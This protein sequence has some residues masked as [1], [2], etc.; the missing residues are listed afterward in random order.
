[1][2]DGSLEMIIWVDPL[3]RIGSWSRPNRRVSVATAGVPVLESKACYLPLNIVNHFST[4]DISSHHKIAALL[5]Y[6]CYSILLYKTRISDEFDQL[7]KCMFDLRKGI[8]NLK[9]N[10]KLES[11]IDVFL[12]FSVFSYGSFNLFIALLTRCWKIERNKYQQKGYWTKQM[13]KRRIVQDCTICI[14]E[15]I[16]L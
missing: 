10:I 7:F 8:S 12:N 11:F 3:L 6:I 2:V 15:A 1:M 16:P 14:C 5:F 9:G 4:L 13:A